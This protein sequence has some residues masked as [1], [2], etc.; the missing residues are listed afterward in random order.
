MNNNT[1]TPE[2]YNIETAYQIVMADCGST[3]LGDYAKSWNKQIGSLL[4]D[5]CVY[6]QKRQLPNPATVVMMDK[7]KTTSRVKPVI[8]KSPNGSVTLA[9]TRLEGTPL[10]NV[11]EI[12][13]EIENGRVYLVANTSNEETVSGPD[14]SQTP[15]LIVTTS[16]QVEEAKATIS[17]T[18]TNSEEIL[19][20]STNN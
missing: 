16:T 3:Y 9:A 20:F 17:S 13:L 10:E 4:V 7:P 15:E 18:G 11:S 6:A 2:T 8:K 1:L 14:S 12:R 19:E 5:L